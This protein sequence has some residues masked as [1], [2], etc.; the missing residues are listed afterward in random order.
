MDDTYKTITA[1]SEGLYKEK[2]SKFLSFAVPCRSAQEALDIV[3]LYRNEYCDAR[4]CCW[5]YMIGPE[6]KEFRSNDDGEPS[7]TAGKPILG[8]INSFELTNL[9][10][11]VV[12]YF[13]G[14]KLG[15][16]GLI[17]AYRTA[18][19]EA[20]SAAQIEERLIEEELQVAFE[21]PLMG[22]V[23][24]IVKEE[25]ATVLAQDFQLSCC[26]HLSLR[27]GQM[28]HMRQRFENLYG[29]TIVNG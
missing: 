20:L 19:Q 25:G 2:M 16:S 1:T 15:T 14:I 6:R 27:R 17:E 3:K 22:D 7:G 26:L 29:A 12:R 8:Q 10:V 11:I 28:P 24:R 18:A 9:V 4:H 21:Y 5:A 13:G 23:M